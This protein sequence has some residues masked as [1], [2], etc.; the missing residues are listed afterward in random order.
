MKKDIIIYSLLLLLAFT[1]C[2]QNAMGTYENDPA[3]YFAHE[4]Y[5]QQD[6]ISHTFFYYDEDVKCD[7]VHVKICTMGMP[8]NYDRP[9]KLEQ[10]NLN[11][12]DA[13]VPGKHFVAFDDPLIIDSI[14][15]PA[16]EVTA[17]IPIVFLRDA[18]LKTQTVRLELAVVGNEYFRPG[19]DEWRNFIVKTTD[20]TVKPTNWDTRWKYYFGVTW[21][22]VKMKFII[23][24]T[25][26]TDFDNTPSDFG[27]LSWLKATAQQALIEYNA[28]HPD[29]P[30]AEA[31]GTLVVMD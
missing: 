29:A 9:I 27:Y 30:L 8:V 14:C 15:I 5:G 20:S 17:D 7:T 18:S 2:E 13:A 16:G 31:D 1:S 26:Y 10:T 25:G 23:D 19:I 3:I 22:P 11:K 12:P 24:C 4:T 6:S 21:G 28:A